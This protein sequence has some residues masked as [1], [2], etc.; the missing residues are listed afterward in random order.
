MF[1]IEADHHPHNAV[2]AGFDG[3][4]AAWEAVH[5]AAGEAAGARPPC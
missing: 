2:I 5:W 4:E 1:D 3:S